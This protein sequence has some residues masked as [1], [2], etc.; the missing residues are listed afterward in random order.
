MGLMERM[1]GFEDGGLFSKEPGRP[2]R[3]GLATGEDLE[4]RLS[5][6]MRDRGLVTL[7]GGLR[8]D[9]VERALM[10]HAGE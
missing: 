4:A 6:G 5:R 2:V 10:V 7:Q 9:A 3:A 8:R 1:F